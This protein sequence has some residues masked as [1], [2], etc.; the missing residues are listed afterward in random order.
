MSGWALG[1]SALVALALLLLL[2]LGERLVQGVSVR[3]LRQLQQRRHAKAFRRLPWL[4]P[5]IPQ[6][7]A[8]LLL[9]RYL[10]LSL[11]LAALLLAGQQA[12]TP[13]LLGALLL[14]PLL[15]M[16]CAEL[17]P[18]QVPVRKLE[19]MS[20]WL[21]PLLVGWHWLSQPLSWLIQ[22]GLQRFLVDF[23]RDPVLSL[24]GNLQGKHRQLMSRLLEL[25]QIRVN[26]LM[27]P[28]TDIEGLDLQQPWPVILERLARCRHRRLVVFRGQLDKLEGVVL[29]QDL[30]PYL[31]QNRLNLAR[32]L[33]LSHEAYFIPAHTPLDIQLDKFR[34]QQQSM[35]LVIDEY[36]DIQGLLTFADILREIT[37]E[38]AEASYYL[39]QQADGSYLLDAAYPL[40]EL[41]RHL[42][43]NLPLERARTLNGL[44]LDYLEQ[45]PQAGLCVRL[46][47]C[48][49]EIIE[50]RDNR[51]QLI[52]LS[53]E[54]GGQEI[55]RTDWPQVAGN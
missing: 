2:A 4:L 20:L 41:N 39:H 46:H 19:R 6:L 23:Q 37:G 10:L 9:A 43:L 52:R 48:V 24:L 50:T 35:G 26:D 7:L 36:G 44:L 49:V 13:G 30:L 29:V 25:E 22:H 31:T 55:S 3:R 5:R 47:G 54:P 14:W 21:V 45:L 51:I 34:S 53:A 11:S 8:S 42:T 18:R 33:A 28:R 15:A 16:L 17:W 12:G 27:V 1:A 38:K 32:L 40:R